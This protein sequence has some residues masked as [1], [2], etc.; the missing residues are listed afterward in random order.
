MLRVQRSSIGRGYPVTRPP[1]ERP[2]CVWCGRGLIGAGITSDG[3]RKAEIRLRDVVEAATSRG[4]HDD[5]PFRG[6][7]YFT[8]V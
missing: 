1:S 5:P 2:E 6:W 3:A 7:S 8:I 4:L